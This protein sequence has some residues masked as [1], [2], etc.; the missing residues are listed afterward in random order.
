[1]L[2]TPVLIPE[3][4]FGWCPSLFLNYSRLCNLFLHYYFFVHIFFDGSSHQT[5]II[6]KYECFEIRKNIN[7]DGAQWESDWPSGGSRTEIDDKL[8]IHLFANHVLYCIVWHFTSCVAIIIRFRNVFIF[9]G[10][11]KFY[12]HFQNSD[13]LPSKFKLHNFLKVVKS[14]KVFFLSSFQDI[15]K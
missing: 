12:Q 13:F 4:L 1:M 7:P 8:S 10:L 5:R 11:T 2:T 6:S 14:S 15:A 9:F 3:S